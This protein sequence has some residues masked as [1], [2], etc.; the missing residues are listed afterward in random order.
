MAAGQQSYLRYCGTCH[1]TDG[2]GKAPAFP[3][4]AG[5]DWLALG[6][7]AVALISLRGLRGEIRVAGEHYRGYMPPMKHVDDADLA[8]ILDYMGSAWADWEGTPDADAVAAIR[9]DHA[10]GAPMEGR[11]GLEAA[12]AEMA[13]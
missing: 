5:S 11:A 8:A 9:R 13:P 10:R 1:G 6:P 4:L 12:L 2:G 3:P 7:E